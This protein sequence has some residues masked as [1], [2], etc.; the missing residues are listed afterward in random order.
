IRVPD[1]YEMPRHQV[2]IN[3]GKSFGHFDIRLSVRDVLAQKAQ[4]KQFEQ[5]T[6]GEI[7][8]VTR[9]YKPGRT[10]SITATYK[11]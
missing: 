6:K 11:M 8:Q 7:Q 2:D 9:S 1:S 5:T 4:F 10:F 3:V